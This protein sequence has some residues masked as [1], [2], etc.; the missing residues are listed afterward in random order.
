MH[1]CNRSRLARVEAKR[2]QGEK[3]R[4]KRR[5]AAASQY[6]AVRG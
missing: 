5:E 4:I 2:Q 6:L 3:A 1:E